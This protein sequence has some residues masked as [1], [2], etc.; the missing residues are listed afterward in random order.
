MAR[1]KDFDW[2][3]SAQNAAKG[4]YPVDCI[5]VNVLMDIRDELRE[6]KQLL[7]CQET[8]RIPRYLRRIANNT[9]KPRPK[10]S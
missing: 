3:M 9:A 5:K 6:I 10:K 2:S 8:L 4:I 1:Y 7:R